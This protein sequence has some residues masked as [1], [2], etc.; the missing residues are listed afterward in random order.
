MAQKLITGFDSNEVVQ[1][2]EN[3]MDKKTQQELID[4]M[5]ALF[6]ERSRALR[7]Y[8]FELLAQ[9]A[10]DLED[11]SQEFEP[12]KE[13]LR[14]KRQKGL[15]DE[16]EFTRQME[17]LNTEMAERKMDLDIEYSDK[18]KAVTEELEKIK[19]DAETE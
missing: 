14:S 4:L 1:V 6:D 18:E 2:T 15:I 17:R 13:L 9:K 16:D 7:K 10:I 12:Q 5:N 3:Y 8:M 19:L 11:L